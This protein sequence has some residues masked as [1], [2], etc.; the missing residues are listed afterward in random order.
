MCYVL[1]VMSGEL[2]A[3]IIGTDTKLKVLLLV[4][5]FQQLEKFMLKQIFTAV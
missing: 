5:L 4:A 3:L 2:K 1:A